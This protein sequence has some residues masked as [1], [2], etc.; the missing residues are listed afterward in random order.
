MNGQGTEAVGFPKDRDPYLSP[1]RHAWTVAKPEKGA[2]VQPGSWIPGPGAPSPS[3]VP[4]PRRAAKHPDYKGPWQLGEQS[5][6]WIWTG[7]QRIFS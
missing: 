3:K 7:D 1:Q 5:E 4:V 6:I 2:A